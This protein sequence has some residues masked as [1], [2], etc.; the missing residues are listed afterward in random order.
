M[1]ASN[2]L[3]P[4]GSECMAFLKSN[5]LMMIGGGVAKYIKYSDNFFLK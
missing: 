2:P 4:S 1:L 3:T 5:K